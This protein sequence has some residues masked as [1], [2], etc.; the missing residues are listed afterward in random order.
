MRL[1]D[2]AIKALRPP[3]AVA[4]T[5]FDDSLA[6]FGVRVSQGGTK[7]YILVH[8]RARTRVAIGR[9]DIISLKQ[10]RDKARDILA[11]QQLGRYQ[12]KTVTFSEALDLY[13]KNHVAKLKPKTERETKRL[14][15]KHFRPKLQHERLNAINRA[16]VAAIAGKLVGYPVPRPPRAYCHHR[17][18][19]LVNGA[20]P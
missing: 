16:S 8:G 10:A 12:E 1:T 14:L 17:L 19:S 5:Y 9:A 3:E 4:K 20:I 6:G 18:F 11:E 13:L 15:E 2:I 7:S